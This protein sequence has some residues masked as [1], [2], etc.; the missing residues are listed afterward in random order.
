MYH[1]VERIL[2]ELFILA[3]VSF[4]VRT[5]NGGYGAL[6]N[7][8]FD[9]KLY[10]SQ[11]QINH[12]GLML[13]FVQAAVRTWAFVIDLSLIDLGHAMGVPGD[14]VGDVSCMKLFV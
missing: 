11:L 10:L 5:K 3:K 8:L 12:A 13:V 14:R 1:K 9:E 4:R 6:F 7:S 2:I